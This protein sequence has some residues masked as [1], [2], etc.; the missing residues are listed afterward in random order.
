MKKTVLPILLGL[1]VLAFVFLGLPL[2]GLELREI[3]G[4]KSAEIEV[5]EDP[6]DPTQIVWFA[7]GQYPA[8]GGCFKLLGPLQYY[9]C[10]Q[11]S[12][13]NCDII[14][15]DDNGTPAIRSDDT[16]VSH[17]YVACSVAVDVYFPGNGS[18]EIIWDPEYATK[19]K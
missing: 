19:P 10:R 16:E 8:L 13:F 12:G 6:I 1:G 4:S 18:M 15:M 7:A 14:V 2:I 5:K 9:E 3:I 11:E 17:E